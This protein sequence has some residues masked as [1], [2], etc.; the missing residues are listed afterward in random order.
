MTNVLKS[1]TNHE[2]LIVI[3]SFKG[4]CFGYAFSKACQHST[5]NEIFCKG[6]RYVSIE[7]VQIDLQKC[8]TWHKKS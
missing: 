8:I 6:F 2:A 4:T 1:I 7:F 5:S 3:E